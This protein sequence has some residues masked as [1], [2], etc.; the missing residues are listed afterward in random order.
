MRILNSKS[1]FNRCK[2]KR[3]VIEDSHEKD[4]IDIG[5]IVNVMNGNKEQE[6]GGNGDNTPDSRT[7]PSM[8]TSRGANFKKRTQQN[9]N[10]LTQYYK[11]RGK[12]K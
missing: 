7:D 2:L 12:K 8:T 11:F 5:S 3:L 6:D 4:K 10:K 1:M 9:H